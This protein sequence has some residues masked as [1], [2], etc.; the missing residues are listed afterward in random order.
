MRNG[1][2]SREQRPLFKGQGKEDVQGRNLIKRCLLQ[3]MP[4]PS[5]IPDAHEG[6]KQ[7]REPLSSLQEGQG[8]T[9]KE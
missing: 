6:L 8:E 1:M 2:L 5:E 3:T 4:E 7:G 9:H